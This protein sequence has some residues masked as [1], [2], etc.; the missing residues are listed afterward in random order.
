MQVEW[1]AD[2]DMGEDLNPRSA[3]AIGKKL[4]GFLKAEGINAA[5]VLVSI[6]REKV[7][8]KDVRFPA[9]SAAEEPAVVRFQATK[10]VTE[11]PDLLE[12]DHAVR[13]Q[14]GPAGERQAL[15]VLT[16]K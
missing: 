11:P 8:L 10:D 13:P 7:L 14:L 9:V 4:H 2:W 16:R 15:A 3:E 1:A 6:G 5:A 12:V